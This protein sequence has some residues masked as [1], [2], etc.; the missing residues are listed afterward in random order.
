MDSLIHFYKNKHLINLTQKFIQNYL[1]YTKNNIYNT[2]KLMFE[3]DN[4]R[5]ISEISCLNE[6]NNITNNNIAKNNENILNTEKPK[7][8]YLSKREFIYIKKEMKPQKSNSNLLNNN[9]RGA[10]RNLLSNNIEFNNTDNTIKDTLH[11]PMTRKNVFVEE[12]IEDLNLFSF[13]NNI[14]DQFLLKTENLDEDNENDNEIDD[15]INKG[16]PT[17][18][19]LDGIDI[20]DY[21]DD[22]DDLY[23]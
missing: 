13:S 19:P 17:L 10:K 3:N 20:D 18:N 12:S 9:N 15:I 21:D 11:P 6:D 5:K 1:L 2:L 23:V 8:K 16:T 4:R 14:A 7:S 22:Y